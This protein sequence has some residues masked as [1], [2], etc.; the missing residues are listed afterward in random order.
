MKL[1]IKI[2]IQ[3]ILAFTGFTSVRGQVFLNGI[4]S[5]STNNERL[6]YVNI[7]IEHKTLE[8]YHYTMEVLT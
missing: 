1:H 8:Q 3:V 7:G 4:V 5:D 6:S 2:S